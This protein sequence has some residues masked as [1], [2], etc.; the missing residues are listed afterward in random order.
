M[1]NCFQARA[2]VVGVAAPYALTAGQ[3]ALVGAIF[4]V[5]ITNADNGA[6]VE[7]S[8]VGVFDLPKEAPLAISAGAR[9]F[10]DNTNKRL[11]TTTTGNFCVARALAAAQSADTTVRALLGPATASA[12]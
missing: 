10:W 12:A 11:T 6:P 8:I 5:A 9:L 4:G 7:L 3:G 2:D 1:K